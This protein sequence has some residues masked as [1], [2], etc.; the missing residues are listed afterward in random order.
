MNFD[1]Y[2]ISKSNGYNILEPLE[3][4]SHGKLLGFYNDLEEILNKKSFTDFFK[5]IKER[6]DKTR[7]KIIIY[8]DEENFSHLVSLWYKSIFKAPSF[9]SIWFI[10]KNYMDKQEVLKNSK[11]AST[12]T[13]FNMFNNLT[14]DIFEKEFFKNENDFLEESFLHEIKS[15][16]SFEILLADYIE[17]ETSKKELMLAI[18]KVLNRCLTELVIEIKHAYV[19]NKNRRNFPI[20][21]NSNFFSNSTLYRGLEL[22]H[23][24]SMYSNVTIERASKEDIE[25]FKYMSNKILSEWDQFSNN[26]DVMKLIDFIDL[27]RKNELTDEDL[28]D[29]INFEKNA[30][31]I[32]RI[33]SSAD[34]EKV[35]IYFLDHV[36]NSKKGDLKR[37]AIK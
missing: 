37:Y 30:K 21:D 1:R 22:G 24:K 3:N 28:S 13:N 36:L 34:E 32:N 5:E 6:C 35:N 18:K 9:D 14:K 11:G 7:R 12:A 15:Q 4:F 23:V 2:V 33:Y 29:I 27:V 8:A 10:L 31:G 17:N 19:R 26:A 16:I 20:K 25:K